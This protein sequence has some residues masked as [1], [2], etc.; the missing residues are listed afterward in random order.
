[1][2]L[3]GNRELAF[4]VGA[5]FISQLFVLGLT[6][7]LLKPVLGPKVEAQSTADIVKKTLGYGW[8]AHLSNILAY[9]NYKADVFLVNLFIGPA[10]VGVYVIAVAMAE[11]LWLMSQAVSTVLLP[12]L[13]QLTDDEHTRKTLTPLI[14]RWV[15]LA[16]LL[17]ALILAFV[18]HW[19]IVM[20]FGAEYSGAV[21]PLWI[22][23]PGIVCSS[24]SRVLSND[25]AAR[26]RPQWNMYTAVVVVT[27]NVIGNILLIPDFGLLGAAT[28]TTIAFSLNLV[29]KL[30][31]YERISG[32][33]WVLSIFI[34]LD[35]IINLTKLIRNK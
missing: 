8:K 32:N 17:A 16:T 1:L 33:R 7:L 13:S 28:A 25:I 2:T 34:R 20:I 14:A 5:Q 24:A 22:L 19:L 15:L 12:R 21:L 18:A 9:V 30:W 27:V 23:L 6:M 31:V 10:A 4:L 26:G 29:M 3:L 35:D 11:K